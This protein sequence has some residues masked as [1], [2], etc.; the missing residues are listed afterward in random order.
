MTVYCSTCGKQNLNSAK[1]C[2]SCGEEFV[3]ITDSG[4]LASAVI[5]DKRY[6]ITRLIKSGGMGGVYLAKDLRLDEPCAV[7]EMYAKCSSPGRAKVYY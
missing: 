4:A 3:T 6:E 5:L 7:K 2:S 1:F